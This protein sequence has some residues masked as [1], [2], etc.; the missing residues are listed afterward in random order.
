MMMVKNSVRQMEYPWEILNGPQ[1]GDV[2]GFL[3][4]NVNGEVLGISYEVLVGRSER[5]CRLE[6]WTNS[7]L[8]SVGNRDWVNS[9]NDR[10][11]RDGKNKDFGLCALRRPH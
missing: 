1:L 6:P 8:R 3:V 9:E 2:K 4:R 10:L 11:V 7:W 5:G